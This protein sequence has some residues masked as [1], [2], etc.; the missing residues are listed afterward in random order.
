MNS[1][2]ADSNMRKLCLR[3]AVYKN[4]VYKYENF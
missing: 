1:K 2:V 3:V 4:F